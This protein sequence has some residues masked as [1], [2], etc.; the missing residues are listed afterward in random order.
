MTTYI[1]HLIVYAPI[2]AFTSIGIGAIAHVS[3][4]Y[5]QIKHFGVYTKGDRFNSGTDVDWQTLLNGFTS[6]CL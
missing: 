5:M 3:A 1:I 2:I 6:I 4:F